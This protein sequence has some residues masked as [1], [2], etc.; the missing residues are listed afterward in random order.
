MCHRPCDLAV[1]SSLSLGLKK[2][3]DKPSENLLHRKPGG[4][5]EASK[6]Q[7]EQKG[8][9]RPRARGPRFSLSQGLVFLEHPGSS[10]GSL[11][12]P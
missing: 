5:L 3:R 2:T 7:Q 6:A 8:S 1:V 4:V 10:P 9:L 12:H 11:T